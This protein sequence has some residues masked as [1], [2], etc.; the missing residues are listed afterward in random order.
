MH[1]VNSI[2]SVKYMY[3]HTY[4]GHDRARMEVREGATDEIRDYLDARYV[5]PAGA[6]WR[7]L[8]YPMHG[9]SLTMQRLVVRR[10]EEQSCSF[11]EQDLEERAHETTGATRGADVTPSMPSGR[12]RIERAGMTTLTM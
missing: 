9:R 5:G 1:I 12:H 7:F 6:A 11:T 2:R 8:E 4:K 3:K 10:F